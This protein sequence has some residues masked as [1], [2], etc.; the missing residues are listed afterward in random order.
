MSKKTS[1]TTAFQELQLLVNE[2]ERG[3]IN[4]DE[5]AEKVKRATE[6]IRICEQKLKDT[7]VNVQQILQELERN[8]EAE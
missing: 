5:L 3:N 8:D 4:V 7:E 1:Y 6:L 2:I